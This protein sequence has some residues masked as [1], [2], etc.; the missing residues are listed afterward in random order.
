M[1]KGGRLAIFVK[2][3]IFGRNVFR[4]QLLSIQYVSYKGS[5]ACYLTKNRMDK[6][7]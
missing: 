6:K 3:Y 1:Q 5:Y 7:L 2:K 4:N